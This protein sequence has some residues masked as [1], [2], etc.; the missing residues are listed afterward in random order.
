MRRAL[1]HGIDRV[2]LTRETRNLPALGGLIPPAI[3][4]YSH[5]LAPPFDLDR[6]RTL[7][8]E[9]G[10]PNGNGL[11]E[12]Q[13]LHADLGYSESHR[14]SE[15]ARWQLWGELGVRLRQEWRKWADPRDFATQ[16]GEADLLEWGWD[17]DYPDPDGML[18][19]LLD[20]VPVSRDAETEALLARARSLRSR[21]ERLALYRAADRRLVAEQVLIVP[22]YYESSYGLYRPWV[23]GFWGSPVAVSPLS[24][25]VVRGR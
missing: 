17:A 10:Y 2:R 19:S 23:E 11:P 22:T 5:D 1:A 16:F 9:A 13:L 4:G 6:A 24:D 15:E 12:L 20:S 7:L 21:D 18:G 8:A 3:P 25:I 14:H